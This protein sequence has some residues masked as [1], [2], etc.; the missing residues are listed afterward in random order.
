MAEVSRLRVARV[1]SAVPTLTPLTM[2]RRV[3]PGGDESRYS[4]QGCEAISLPVVGTVDATPD[5]IR[6]SGRVRVVAA[7]DSPEK[8]AQTPTLTPTLARR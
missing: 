7:G 8:L 4:L 3:K 6:G 2:D 1:H 5:F